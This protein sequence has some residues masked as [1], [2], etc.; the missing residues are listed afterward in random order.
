MVFRANHI[1]YL[2][3]ALIICLPQCKSSTSPN[4]NLDELTELIGLPILPEQVKYSWVSKSDSRFPGP[5]D[6]RLIVVMNYSMDSL[7][8]LMSVLEPFEYHDKVYWNDPE[9]H[10]LSDSLLQAMISYDEKYPTLKVNK[11]TLGWLSKERKGLAYVVGSMLYM[12][13]E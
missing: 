10:W 3:V 13:C 4:Q 5:T 1:L 8:K 11:Y 6:A 12:E 7:A 2:W 9:L